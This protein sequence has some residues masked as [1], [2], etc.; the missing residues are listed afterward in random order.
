MNFS[1]V[2][3]DRAQIKSPAMMAAVR[4]EQTSILH[5]KED[6]DWLRKVR[7]RVNDD[8]WSRDSS[9]GFTVVW[10]TVVDVDE[11]RR[12]RDW[13]EVGSLTNLSFLS[14]LSD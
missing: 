2:W 11:A 3:D 8:C 1:G 6:R 5:P 4:M 9:S 13:E 10:A 7:A 12:M 14:A